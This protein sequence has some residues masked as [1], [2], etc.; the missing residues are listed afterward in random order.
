MVKRQRASSSS[1]FLMELIIAIMLFCLASSICILAF[2]NS[3]LMH[4]SSTLSNKAVT[5]VQNTAESIRGGDTTDEI[6][7]NLEKMYPSS[8]SSV[9]QTN[10]LNKELIIPLGPDLTETKDDTPF[11]LSLECYLDD[12]LFC[13]II[14]F[15]ND[16]EPVYDLYVEHIVN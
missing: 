2:V 10:L 5:L 11:N 8:F 7:N 1:L 3:H 6:I 4:T 13:S 15:Y 16:T 14:T 12:G 9:N